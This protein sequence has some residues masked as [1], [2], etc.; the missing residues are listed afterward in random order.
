[1]ADPVTGREVPV[2][3]L[4]VLP[5]GKI[6]EEVPSVHMPYLITEEEAKIIPKSRAFVCTQLEIVP[7]VRLMCGLPPAI[8]SRKDSLPVKLVFDTLTSFLIAMLA[9]TVTLGAVYHIN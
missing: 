5:A 7:V 3:L 8:Y 1:S 9:L 6:P 2:T 4:I